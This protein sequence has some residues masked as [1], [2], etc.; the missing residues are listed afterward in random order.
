MCRRPSATQGDDS[1]LCRNI[2]EC[3]PWNRPPVPTAPSVIPVPYTGRGQGFTTFQVTAFDPDMQDIGGSQ[4][5][6]E[7]VLYRFA[8]ED[9]M[10]GVTTPCLRPYS[11]EPDACSP[12]NYGELVTL[13]SQ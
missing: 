11:L 2:G 4:M 6:T 3:N 7:D 9:E 12:M 8:T 5:R 13:I 10:G 1:F